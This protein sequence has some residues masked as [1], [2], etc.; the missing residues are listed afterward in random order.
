MDPILTGQTI[1]VGIDFSQCSERALL[2]AVALAEQRQ[3]QLGLIHVFE[4]NLDSASAD[5]PATCAADSGLWREVTAQAQ[6]ARRRLSHL[7]TSFVGDRVPAEVYVLIG[8]PTTEMLKLAEQRAASLIVL[9]A[10][11]RSIVRSSEY[12]TM[13]RSVCAGSAIPVLLVPLGGG[14]QRCPGQL[15]VVS[16]H[17]IALRACTRCGTL[18][19]W[20]AETCGFCGGALAIALPA[21][22][23]HRPLAPGNTRA[24]RDVKELDDR[25]E[26]AAA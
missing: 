14:T 23:P 17:D 11:G 16:S 9:G 21:A 24:D 3:A 5:A 18:Q 6:A 12:G 4:W 26:F 7:C 13:A 2:H 25:R 8:N 15:F 19:Q 1:L 10:T 22:P 20:S